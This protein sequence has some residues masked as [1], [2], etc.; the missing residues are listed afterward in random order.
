M[1]V[2]SIFWIEE[3][4][5]EA[6]V[7]VSDGVFGLICFSCPCSYS[8]GDAVTEKLECLDAKKIKV[9]KEGEYFIEKGE[10]Y[11]S[12]KICGKIEDAKG[13][14]IKLGDIELHIDS[15]KIPKDIYENQYIVFE[16]SRIDMW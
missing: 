16:T 13:G 14:I 4:C 8:E 11:F 1:F 6:E 9:A 15:S 5:R 2:K 10:G 3:S 12:Y 7:E